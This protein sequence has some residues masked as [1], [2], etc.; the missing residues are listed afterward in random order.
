MTVSPRSV[1]VAALAL[2]IRLGSRTSTAA[3]VRRAAAT[4]C[5]GHS[6]VPVAELRFARTAAAKGGRATQLAEATTAER[7][8]AAYVVE[9][10]VL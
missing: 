2:S 3:G 5:Q 1:E 4:A 7:D 10:P 6:R 9:R 8:L